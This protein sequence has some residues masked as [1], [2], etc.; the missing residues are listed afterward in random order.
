MER[1]ADNQIPQNPPA[2]VRVSALTVAAKYRSKREVYNLLAV[3]AG[4]YLP[5]YGMDHTAALIL[6]QYHLTYLS[7]T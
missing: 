1:Q 6:L 5:A 2:K 3:D 4:V 7:F